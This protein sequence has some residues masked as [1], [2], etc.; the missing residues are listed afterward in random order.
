LPGTSGSDLRVSLSRPAP[1]RAEL[2]GTLTL[3]PRSTG[4]VEEQPGVSSGS[5]SLHAVLDTALGVVESLD[6]SI[7]MQ[8]RDPRGGDR[9]VTV[10]QTTSL[11]RVE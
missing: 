10:R 7:E 1:D 2:K 3:A 9:V 4:V 6:V 11:K 5:F 8:M